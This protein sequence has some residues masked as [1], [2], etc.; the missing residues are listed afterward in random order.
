MERAT[1]ALDDEREARRVEPNVW[2]AVLEAVQ[3][4]RVEQEQH[5]VRMSRGVFELWLEPMPEEQTTSAESIFC[6]SLGLASGRE[7]RLRAA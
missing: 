2:I 3:A 7:A 1:D 4:R 6:T 5:P